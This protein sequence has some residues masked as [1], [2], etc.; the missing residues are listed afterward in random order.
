MAHV[1]RAPGEVRRGAQDRRDQDQSQRLGPGHQ[2][3]GPGQPDGE[4]VQQPAADQPD[5]GPGGDRR[6]RRRAQPAAGRLL[7]GRRSGAQRTVTGGSLDLEDQVVAH[8]D[9]ALVRLLQQVGHRPEL[10]CPR[11]GPRRATAAARRRAGRPGCSRRRDGS[12][13]R[14]S[15]TTI[16][17]TSRVRGALGTSPRS[18]SKASSIASAVHEAARGQRGVDEHD[19]VEVVLGL[20]RR[21][22]RLGLV[23]RR[24]P[25]DPH[26]RGV[27]DRVDR[28]PG[29]SPS[30]RPGSTPAPAPPAGWDASHRSGCRCRRCAG[31]GSQSRADLAFPG[32]R[33]RDVRER[34]VDGRVRL[35]DRHPR[36]FNTIVPRDRRPRSAGRG[37]RS[38][39]P[40][41]STAAF[42][43]ATRL[44]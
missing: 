31:W 14:R 25:G 35:V 30:A 29:G 16:R 18:R 6:E 33:E 27:G 40:D 22:H 20:R 43:E 7:A 11:S 17:S 4:R 36:P 5:D 37:S 1:D 15:P 34:R 21:V 19:G 13:L 3:S 41:P 2:R 26:V 44:P 8:R 39:R 38:G 10:G 32:D 9:A 12:S 28:T 24:D 42:T 23:D